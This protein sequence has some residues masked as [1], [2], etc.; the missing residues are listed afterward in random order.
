MLSMTRS[1]DLPEPTTSTRVVVRVRRKKRSTMRPTVMTPMAT[2]TA[3]TSWVAYGSPVSKVPCRDAPMA[4]ASTAPQPTPKESSRNSRN[5]LGC[6]RRR[7]T[8]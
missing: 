1:A 7:A 6:R 4:R 5:A 3:M 2:M 8:R